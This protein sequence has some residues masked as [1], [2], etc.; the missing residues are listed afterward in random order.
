VGETAAARIGIRVRSHE[1]TS[2]GTA[3]AGLP[4]LSIYSEFLQEKGRPSV[5]YH[6]RMSAQLQ[7][8][9]PVQELCA[10][11]I[12]QH[13][14]GNWREAER[15]Y[16]DVL[17]ID[18][19]HADSLHLLG[20]IATGS[21]RYDAAVEWIG[22]AL[23]VAPG[24][25]AA[26]HNLGN[27]LLA[28]G[29]ADAAVAAYNT[30]LRLQPRRAAGHYNLANALSRL[31]RLDEA[32]ENYRIALALRPDYASAFNNLGNALERVGR[33]EEAIG[34]YTEALEHDPHHTEAC[35]N[36]AN[37]LKDVGRTGEARALYEQADVHRNPQRAT[38][39]AN[40]ALLLMEMGEVAESQQ[41]TEQAL[42]VDPSCV[43]AWHIRAQLKVFTRGDPDIDSMEA[44]LANA[45]SRGMPREEH[46]R[47]EFSLG[48]AWLDTGETDRAF[49]HF[50]RGNQL[51]RA[52][53]TY[54]DATT[55]RWLTNIART[56]TPELLRAYSGR[57]HRTEKPVFV[58][59][60]PRS[61]TTLVE[62]ILASHPD[63]YGAGE[64][65]ILPDLVA[66]LCGPEAD[67][68]PPGLPQALL[69]RLSPLDLIHLGRAYENRATVPGPEKRRVVDKMPANFSY[70]GLI[71][72][73]LP[74]ARIIHCRRDPADTCLSCYTK[75][76]RGAVPFAYDLRELGLYYRRYE[77]LMAHW[78]ALLPPERFMELHYEDIVEDLEHQ[79]RRLVAFCGLAWNESCLAFHATRR[80]IQTASAHQ[81]I[82]PIYR[83][84]VGRAKRY[85]A[86][87]GPLLAVLD[88][89]AARR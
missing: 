53:L 42:S 87:L 81:V 5:A 60:M 35:N 52:T 46:I 27:A 3:G 16:R 8:G 44:V 69:A 80:Q 66:A 22:R 20:V 11:G 32:I 73:I 19:R 34:A 78:R 15:L 51:K 9:H 64:L 13:R 55:G 33:L 89:E 41:I 48:K 2:V 70:V 14:A 47:L 30:G 88:G 54:D 65:Q 43:P 84:S 28:L 23:E 18:P 38:T 56:F 1:E 12:R 39:L 62:Q 83:T 67:L 29:R 24:F 71:H 36:L 58:V 49:S 59:G 26:H 31:G 79:A 85:A 21:G 7:E 10:E 74:D 4:I 77:A 50:H 57:G 82:R 6:G 63:V 17:T 61:G 37:T 75:T 68:Q 25:A 86:H 40:K 72:L 45:T 76:F